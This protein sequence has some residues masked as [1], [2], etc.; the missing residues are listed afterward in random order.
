VLRALIERGDL[1]QI[2]ED[3]LL[4]AEVYGEM[5]QGALAII[6]ADGTVS[7]K[8]LRD[9]FNTSR[10]YAIA[11]LEHLDSLGITRR[12]GDERVRGKNAPA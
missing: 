10:K 4:S 12:V 5:R 7:A 3:V 11:L 8:A 6:D 1:V 2:A 9:R